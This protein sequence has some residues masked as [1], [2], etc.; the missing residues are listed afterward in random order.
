MM[1]IQAFAKKWNMLPPGGLILCAVSGGRDSM[2]LL[3]L[4]REMGKKEG[5]QVHAA[6]FNHHIRPTADRDQGFVMGWCGAMGIP[7]TCGGADAAA[8]ARELGTSLEDGARQLRYR[9][10]EETADR[11]GAAR[12]ATA[13]HR[14]DNAETV[15]LHLLRGSGLRGLGGIPPV[16][17]RIVRPLLETSRADIDGYVRRHQ[18]PYVDDETNADTRFTRNRLRL[19]VFPL[20]EE[21]SPG[22]TGRIA[23]A[24]DLLREDDEHFRGAVDASLFTFK[25]DRAEIS[26]RD[27]NKL[28]Q[29]MARRTVREMSHSLLGDLDRDN[30]EQVLGLGAG[31]YLDLPGRQCAFRTRTKLTLLR[32]PVPP[33]PMALREGTQ[34]WWRWLVQ[35]Y[36]SREPVQEDGQTAVLGGCSAP[37]TIAAWDGQGS[38]GVENGERTIK[39]LF[40]DRRIPIQ[41]RWE[42]PALYADG[43]PAAVFG[44]ATDRTLR[45]RP[46]ESCLVVRIEEYRA[47]ARLW[48][49]EVQ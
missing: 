22:C 42:H 8:R 25:G 20:L 39:R 11:V 5:F 23:A 13:H 14:E 7:L 26:L 21:I 43:R 19:E 4:L 28:D 9:F 18:I 29:S 36:L 1:N 49:G 48:P 27:L 10:L 34:V 32:L 38:L 16:R 6:H 35:V 47:M 24:A 46:G 41:D 37:L 17:G 33:P 12:I 3:H 44:V 40:T 15:L 31:G 30:V 2:A 45:P